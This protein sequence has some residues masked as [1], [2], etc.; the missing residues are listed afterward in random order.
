MTDEISAPTPGDDKRTGTKKPRSR[1]KLVAMFA[2]GALIVAGG[3]TVVSV[4]ASR[5]SAEETTRMCTVALDA[6]STATKDAAQASTAADKALGAV[7]NT[8]LPKDAGT[9]TAYEKRPAIKAAKAVPARASG[10][11]FTSDV[12]RSKA[13]LAGITIPTQCIDRDQ[14]D[15]I[16]SATT[17]TGVATKTLNT[18]IEALKADFTVFQADEAKCL[19]AEKKAAA[20]KAAAT[21]KKAEAE[22]AAKKKAAAAAA[23]EAEAA[24]AAAAA[25]EAAAAQAQEAPQYVA[26][27]AGGDGGGYVPAAP[28]PYVPAA[29]APYVP[30]P[31]PYVPAPAPVSGGSSGTP[32]GG[33]G[34]VI[35]NDGSN[36]ACW[37]SNGK[38][39]IM[40]C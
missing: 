10:A 7:K 32:G 12:A 39:G 35:S 40:P 36:K 18:S 2:A 38:G 26:P 17:K 20:E 24:R 8:K 33:G 1:K 16:S 15:V 5:A 30:A 21:K 34:G 6:G 25:Q 14:A 37:T 22:A 13:A 11:D 23:A 28:A 4:T 3:I 27:Q 29:P 9:S 31:A 19:A